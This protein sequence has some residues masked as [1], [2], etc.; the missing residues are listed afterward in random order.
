MKATVKTSYELGFAWHVFWQPLQNT[1]ITH[2]TA[3][4]KKQI[5]SSAKNSFILTINS[6]YHIFN[7]SVISIWGDP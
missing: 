2:W 5:L 7:S 1:F 3:L 6:R 4:D